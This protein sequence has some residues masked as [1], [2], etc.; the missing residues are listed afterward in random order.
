MIISNH[1]V[2]VILSVRISECACVSLFECVRASVDAR[3]CGCARVWMRAS[4]NARECECA[5]V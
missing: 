3:E 5:R 1:Y 2:S 4:V